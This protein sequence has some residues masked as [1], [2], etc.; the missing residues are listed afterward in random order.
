MRVIVEGRDS[1]SGFCGTDEFRGIVIR[2]PPK[3]F[4]TLFGLNNR[5]YGYKY[6]TL[7]YTIHLNIFLNKAKF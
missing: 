1:Q 6:C 3:L 5:Y 7:A 2:V 4:I